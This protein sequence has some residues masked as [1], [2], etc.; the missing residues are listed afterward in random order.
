MVRKEPKKTVLATVISALFG[1]AAAGQVRAQGGAE[2][3][4]EEVVVTG[5]RG[6]IVRALDQKRNAIGVSDSISARACTTLPM[7]GKIWVLR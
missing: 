6:S 2:A 3:G 1:A 7:S 4:I 5:V